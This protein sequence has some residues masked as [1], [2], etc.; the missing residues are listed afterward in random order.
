MQ[1]QPT[2]TVGAGTIGMQAL[3]RSYYQGREIRSGRR[4]PHDLPR[5]SLI[6][7]GGFG[8]YSK[9]YGT[10][11][12]S[13][14]EAEVVTADG[15]IRIANASMNPDLFWALKKGRRRRDVFGVMSR[16]TVRMHELP[17]YFGGANLNVKAS[18]DDAYRSLIREFVSF[19]REHLFNDHWGEQAHVRP[20][21]VLETR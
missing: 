18:S 14:L 15:Q 7:G 12:G 13:L 9:H 3:Q 5:R 8:S 11:A 20:D 19:Y 21:N 10:A 6:S 4:M 16:M 2:V 17:E 1:P